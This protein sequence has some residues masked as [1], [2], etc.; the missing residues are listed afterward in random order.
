MDR[1]VIT[2]VNNFRRKRTHAECEDVCAV[3]SASLLQDMHA[4][5]EQFYR[6]MQKPGGSATHLLGAYMDV[7]QERRVSASESEWAVLESRVRT[8]VYNVVEHLLWDMRLDDIEGVL[9]DVTP[10]IEDWIPPASRQ[11]PFS[12]LH[13][14]R[15]STPEHVIDH[16]VRLDNTMTQ[17]R[18][19]YNRTPLLAMTDEH[20]GTFVTRAPV[21]WTPWW[22]TH[23]TLC[24]AY[25]THAARLVERRRLT[26]CEQLSQCVR[27]PAVRTLLGNGGGDLLTPDNIEMHPIINTL[28]SELDRPTASDVIAAL[29][30]ASQ[31]CITYRSPRHGI[32]LLQCSPAVATLL[33]GAHVACRLIL[34]RWPCTT[35]LVHIEHQGTQPAIDFLVQCNAPEHSW[36]IS[37]LLSPM[38]TDERQRIY[39]LACREGNF[40]LSTLLAL[41]EPHLLHLRDRSN[42]DRTAVTAFMADPV[43]NERQKLSALHMLP[44]KDMFLDTM[45]GH[46]MTALDYC[47]LQQIQPCIVMLLRNGA[48]CSQTQAKQIR[49]LDINEELIQPVVPSLQRLAFA[50]SNGQVCRTCNKDTEHVLYC[51]F[52]HLDHKW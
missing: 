26:V 47:I 40:A 50:Q 48:R 41:K 23:D 1:A 15:T 30:S 25:S 3:P 8:F 9:G 38:D 36:Y 37:M 34:E 18:D 4:R 6:E 31:L 13:L 29:E 17:R 21:P 42:H 11:R 46:G 35:E 52:M 2:Q 27:L 12:L 7:L 20:H 19:M 49:A 43:L 32:L 28:L 22:E 16:I 10:V 51:I 5:E 14:C 45:D 24:D 44:L 39:H 33:M